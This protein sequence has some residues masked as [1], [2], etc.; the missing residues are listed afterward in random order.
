M[1]MMNINVF[2]SKTVQFIYI[3]TGAQFSGAYIFLF[4]LF[5]LIGLIIS[6][7]R[8][9]YK[10]GSPR[11]IK[12]NY[13]LFFFSH[14]LLCINKLRRTSVLFFPNYVSLPVYVKQHKFSINV[15]LN[16]INKYSIW[17]Y[18]LFILALF[19]NANRA[20]QNVR[21]RVLY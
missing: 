15:Y 21:V 20:L 2:I 4:F 17:Q 13:R 10:R 6:G 19:L 12:F 11:L 14:S 7:S 18:L 8:V 3:S 5:C 1:T 16:T 9:R